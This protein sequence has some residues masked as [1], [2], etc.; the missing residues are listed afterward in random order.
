M[1]LDEL[2]Y[3]K[4]AQSRSICAENPTG[5]KGGGAMA[6]PE[7]A[8]HAAR[9]LGK[10]WKVSPNIEIPAHTVATLADIHDMGI[11][12]HIWMTCYP[13]TWRML[14]LRFYWDD[15][16]FPSVEVPIGD[17]FCNG[18][19]QRSN[20]KS[21]PVSVNPAGGFNCYWAM[22]FRKAAKITVENLS[23]EPQT[24]FFQ[25]DY[26]LTEVPDDACYFHA[27]FRR[28]NP[29]PYKEE[30]VIVDKIEGRG[31]YV[32]TYMAWQANNN[33][34]WGEGEIKM[35]IDNDGEYPTI[36]G[37]GTEDYFGGAWNFEDVPGEYH[38]YT[39]L[40]HGMHVFLPGNIYH[41]NTR[42]GLYRWHI[43]DP[44]HFET[45]LHVT[46]QDLGWRSEGRFLPR[47]DDIASVAFWYQMEPHRKFDKLPDKDDLEVI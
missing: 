13:D 38:S 39:N 35:Y 47:R 42:F 1:M 45:N 32:G 20:I 31:H 8:E 21:I 44:V 43:P 17:F 34:W 29:V 23:R 33:G 41:E 3:A 5:A 18:W 14:V 28:T 9:E 4:K 6:E 15:E 7:G 12:R 11:I 19:C 22:P 40:Y 37:T 36:C 27:M 16:T 26:E 46:M 24:L 10:G 30:Y 25:V 2:M